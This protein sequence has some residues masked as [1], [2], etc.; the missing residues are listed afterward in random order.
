LAT[1]GKGVVFSSTVTLFELAFVTARSGLPWPLKSALVIPKGN[2]PAGKGLPGAGAKLTVVAADAGQLL[3]QAPLWRQQPRQALLLR[4]TTTTYA[5]VGLAFL[6]TLWVPPFSKMVYS[7]R[8][9]RWQ[10]LPE[11]PLK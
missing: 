2:D 11:L 8:P 10:L 5:K 3:T 4:S 6:R 9:K 1:G 7:R